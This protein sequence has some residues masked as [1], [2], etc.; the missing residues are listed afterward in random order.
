VAE[1]YELISLVLRSV[2]EGYEL[3]LRPVA[4]G[5]EQA[6][7][8]HRRSVPTGELAI[9]GIPIA[10]WDWDSIFQFVNLWSSTETGGSGWSCG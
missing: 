1:G 8:R 2:A 9:T 3:I 4:M 6:A 7:R 5:D 10:D